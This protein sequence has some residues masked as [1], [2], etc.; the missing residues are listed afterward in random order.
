MNDNHEDD[1]NQNLINNNNQMKNQN[2][3]ISTYKKD[4]SSQLIEP[5]AEPEI[6]ANSFVRKD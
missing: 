4:R 5:D 3:I 2:L 6:E 1:E